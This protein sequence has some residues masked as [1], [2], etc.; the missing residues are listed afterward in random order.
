MLHLENRLLLDSIQ[1][2]STTATKRAASKSACCVLK[3][4]L[5]YYTIQKGYARERK[6]VI[7]IILASSALK[8]SV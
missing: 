6:L 5:N 4:R 7:N 1:L 2:S 8:C 3:L